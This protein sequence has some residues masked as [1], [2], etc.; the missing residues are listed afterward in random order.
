[1]KRSTNIIPLHPLLAAC[2]LWASCNTQVPTSKESKATEAPTTTQRTSAD[3]SQVDAYV[4]AAFEDSKGNLWFGT[5]GQ[6]VAR[7]DGNV[8][9]YFS[10]GE[11][12]IDNV[13]TGIAEDRDGNLWFGTQAGTSRYDGNTFTSFG[14]A[15]GLPGAGR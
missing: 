12:L 9:R 5:N 3:T 11:G 10:I 1:M 8:L 13:V 14:P 6:G 15:E 7:W 2:L 4:V